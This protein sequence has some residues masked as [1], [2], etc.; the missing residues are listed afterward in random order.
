MS[1]RNVTLPPIRCASCRFWAPFNATVGVCRRTAPRPAEA[2]DTVAHWPETFAEEGCA[3]GLAKDPDSELQACASCAYWM[4]SIAYGGLEPVDYNDQPR[5]WWRHAGRC[6]R[7]APGPLTAP[8]LRLVWPA[9][10]EGDSCGEGAHG[11]PRSP[12]GRAA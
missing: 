2:T 8:G 11:A 5:V 7:H 1:E 9:T 3:E 4:P 10:H 12:E 6:V